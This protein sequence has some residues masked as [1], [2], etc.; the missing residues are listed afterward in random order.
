[1][2]TACLL[3]VL[4]GGCKEKKCRVL[5]FSH[6]LHAVENEMA[7]ADCHGEMK[8]GGWE[9]AG[10][11]QCTDCHDDVIETEKI[12]EKTC[13]FC[14]KQRNLNRITKRSDAERRTSGTFVHTEALK[15][16]CRECHGNI[17][18]K[19]LDH[20]PMLS[21]R[22]LIRVMREDCVAGQECSV[23]HAGMDPKIPPGS[24]HANWTRLHGERSGLDNAVCTVCHTDEDSCRECHASTRP[25]SHNTLWRT[26]T[27]GIRAGWERGNC[28]VCHEEDF[29]VACHTETKPRSHKAAW[30]RTHCY[31]CHTS[32][33]E[34]TGCATCHETTLESHGDPH[35]VGWRKKHCSRCHDGGGGVQQC[36]LCHGEVSDSHGNPHKGNWL[37]SHCASCHQDGSDNCG[38]CHPGG[39][40]VFV[41]EGT[42]T[43]IH[44]VFGTTWDCLICH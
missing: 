3:V 17:L 14:H 13:G 12:S 1:M 32:G 18:K 28:R 11:E 25:S 42:W 35:E 21:K 6:H 36:D 44:D 5:A 43:P 34:G 20:V 41:H 24:H 23:C 39:S 27:H 22:T 2:I 7:C 10:H 8:D 15:P 37:D 31:S 19:G 29:C 26:K 30:D 33:S 38:K 16:R 9:R 4:H 40:S